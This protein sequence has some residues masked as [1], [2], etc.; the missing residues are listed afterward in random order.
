MPIAWTQEN[1]SPGMR[2]EG[3]TALTGRT[4]VKTPAVLTATLVS[5]PNHTRWPKAVTITPWFA[6]G[7]Y[8]VTSPAAPVEAAT[9][10]HEIKGRH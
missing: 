3:R 1:G 10:L 8:P 4:P 6:T 9:A 2:R 5:P 7:A